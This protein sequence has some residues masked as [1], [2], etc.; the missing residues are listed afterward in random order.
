MTTK[1]ITVKKKKNIYFGKL[2]QDKILEY[3]NQ[4]DSHKKQ[5]IY[6][7]YIYP[8]FRRVAQSQVVK[9]KIQQRI[10]NS[11]IIQQQCLTKMTDKLSLFNDQKGRAFSF[12]TTIARN[13]VLTQLDKTIKHNQKFKSLNEISLNGIEINLLQQCSYDYWENQEKKIKNQVIIQNTIEQLIKYLKSQI[14]PKIKRQ[15][16]LQVTNVVVQTMQNI[17][18]IEQINKK[19]LIQDIAIKSNT[20]INTVQNILRKMAIHYYRFKNNQIQQ[21]YY[22]KKQEIF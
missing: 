1:P 19:N 21:V 17:N 9:Y 20:S 13:Y 4:T 15:Q 3:N 12:F 8:A 11:K 7:E 2:V 14:I 5:R 16:Q 6:Q 18:D 10:Q 22:K